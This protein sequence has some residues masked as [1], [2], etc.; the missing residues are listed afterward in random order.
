LTRTVAHVTAPTGLGDRFE[1][2][3]GE[4]NQGQA[5]WV[6]GAA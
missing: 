4:N 1:Q 5:G 3:R 2:G 6:S